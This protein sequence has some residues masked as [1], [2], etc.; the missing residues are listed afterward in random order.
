MNLRPIRV[1]TPSGEAELTAEGN[2]VVGR[3]RD[4]DLVIPDARVSRR[5]L[6]LEPTPDGWVARDLSSNGMWRDNVRTG[7]VALTG[8]E[9]R[10]R[11]GAIDGPL[12]ILT[13]PPPPPLAEPDVDD[14]ETMLAGVGA[15]A[16]APAAAAP[17]TAARPVTSAAAHAGDGNARPAAEP[18]PR[19]KASINWLRVVPTYLWLAGIG[20]FLGALLAL[21]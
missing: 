6:S 18:A 20:F 9:V 8:G 13:P 16:R 4:C 14:Q 10:I 19:S 5:H 12:V 15:P 2:R 7:V 21:S 11:L 17:H 1:V 3:G